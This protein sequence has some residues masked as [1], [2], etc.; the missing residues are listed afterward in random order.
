MFLLQGHKRFLS[1]GC[2]AEGSVVPTGAAIPGSSCAWETDVSR[3]AR[4]RRRQGRTDLASWEPSAEPRASRLQRRGEHTNQPQVEEERWGGDLH[5][6]VSSLSWAQKTG[7]EKPFEF[8]GPFGDVHF[9]QKDKS[10]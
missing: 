9:R 3:P 5:H 8:E 6:P 7:Q 4:Q 10:K 2:P 1:S